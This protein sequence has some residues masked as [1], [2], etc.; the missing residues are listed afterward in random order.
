[1]GALWRTFSLP[2]LDLLIGHHSNSYSALRALSC[3]QTH[4]YEEILDAELQKQHGE[5]G[6][7]RV[8][9]RHFI[10]PP[11]ECEQLVHQHRQACWGGDATEALY[12]SVSD[13]HEIK[14]H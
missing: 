10:V 6:E 1:M 4:E 7:E 3:A 5:A 13:F 2:I 9:L 11:P 12:E 8:H 14:L